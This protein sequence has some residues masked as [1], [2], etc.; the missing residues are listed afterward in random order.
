MP[1]PTSRP[2]SLHGL[3]SEVGPPASVGLGFLQLRGGLGAVQRRG[4]APGVQVM[5]MMMIMMILMMVCRQAEF[6]DQGIS[7]KVGWMMFDQF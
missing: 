2:D 6:S 4:G 1:L 5:R 3:V 7:V